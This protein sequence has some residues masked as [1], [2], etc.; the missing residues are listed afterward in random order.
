MNLV[1]QTSLWS[2][3]AA[4]PALLVAYLVF[5]WQAAAG[6]AIGVALAIFEAFSFYYISELLAPQPPSPNTYRLTFIFIVLK[7]PL[8]GAAV[9]AAMAMGARGLG[10]FLFAIALVY[11]LMVYVGLRGARSEQRDQFS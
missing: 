6:L 7:L 8:I 2:I 1:R 5:Q 11:S 4:S 10:G 9:Y 3:R